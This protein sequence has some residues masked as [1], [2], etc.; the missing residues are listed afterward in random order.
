MQL[1]K[2]TTNVSF[3]FAAKK[4]EYFYKKNILQFLSN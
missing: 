4:T 3:E 1:Q 2:G